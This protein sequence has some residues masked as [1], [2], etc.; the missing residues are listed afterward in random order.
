MKLDYE[1]EDAME[2]GDSNWRPC[3][4]S[5]Q[6]S[7]TFKHYP[8]KDND[9]IITRGIGVSLSHS[10]GYNLGVVSVV[11]GSYSFQNW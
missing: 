4:S 7:H 8:P 11:L 1:K 5:A 9:I 3:F 6:L 10:V 2:L